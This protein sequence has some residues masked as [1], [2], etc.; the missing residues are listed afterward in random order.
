MSTI[1]SRLRDR[2]E[3]EMDAPTRTAARA[4]DDLRIAMENV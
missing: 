2:N 3:H 1:W 4:Q